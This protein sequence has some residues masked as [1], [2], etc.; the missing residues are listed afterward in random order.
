MMCYVFECVYSFLLL[1]SE[2]SFPEG[3][4]CVVVSDL[5]V[6]N[7]QQSLPVDHFQVAVTPSSLLT[8]HTASPQPESSDTERTTQPTTHTKHSL[9]KW[10]DSLTPIKRKR[11]KPYWTEEA[12]DGNHFIWSTFHVIEFKKCLPLLLPPKRKEMFHQAYL[13][14]PIVVSTTY[15]D[16]QTNLKVKGNTSSHQLFI[17]DL[18]F[19]R[20]TSF[21]SFSSRL[22]LVYVPLLFDDTDL[23]MLR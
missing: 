2:S 15:I 12:M 7:W 13:I 6:T 17:A 14:L 23:G 22:M 10:L 16:R 9:P 18:L 5:K 3:C 11:V 1:V 20:E 4:L 19:E 21:I 8:P